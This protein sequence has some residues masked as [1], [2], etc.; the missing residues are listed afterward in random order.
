MNII[1]KVCLCIAVGAVLST[2]VSAQKNFTIAEATNGLSG[3]LAVQGLKQG[4]WRPGTN[5]LYYVEKKE[6]VEAWYSIDFPDEDRDELLTLAKLN[7]QLGTE[8]KSFPLMTWLDEDHVYIND[9]KK[10]HLG[11]VADDEVKDWKVW[12]TLPEKAQNITIDEKRNI[13]YTIDNNLYLNTP[14][15]K[16]LKV[17][18][19]SNKNIISGQAVHRNEFGIDRGIFLS[20]K[21]NYLA[22]YHMDQSMVNDYPIINWASD[23]ATVEN[24]KYP[25]AGGTSHQVLLKVYDPASGKTVT[26]KTGEGKD[27]YL[28]AVT[29]SPDEKHVYAGLL[30]REQNHLWLN[31]YDARTGAKLATLFEETSDKYV[32]PQHPLYFLPGSDNEFLWWSQKDGY[33]HLYLYNTNGE[34]LRQVTKG[35]WVVNEI[36]GFNRKNSEVLITGTKE[37][38]LGKN[39]YAANWK[40][41]ELRRLDKAEG[42]HTVSANTAGTYL[43]DVHTSDKVPRKYS[44]REVKG[45]YTKAL[46]VSEDPLKSYNRAEVRN[47]TLKA[48]DGT[49]LYGKLVLPPNFD[50]GKKY[51]TVVY[52]Y[53]GP[54]AQMIHNSYPASGNLWYEYMA[55]NGFIMFTIDGRGSSNRGLAF[56]QATFRKLGDVEMEDQLAGVTYLKSLPYVDAKRMGVHG[57]SYGGFM[58]TSLMLRHPGVFKAAVAGGPVMDWSMYEV[59]YTERY[60]DTPLENPE[61]YKNNNLYTKVKSLAGKLLLIHGASDDVVV[62][63]HSVKFLKACVDEN[64]QVDYFVYP[65]HPHNVRGKDRVHLMQKITDYFVEN[66]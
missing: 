24:I 18:D 15:G 62:W 7:K 63:Q 58:T 42:M 60:M 26:L 12:F 36:T 53:N 50:P 4:T 33:M 52:L 32:E 47:V 46:L 22:Y 20:P 34:Q 45:A 11:T 21:G 23:P 17:T 28:V 55:Q 31:K 38:P 40:N 54:H 13:A 30:N 27:H 43:Y 1:K 66:L 35:E 5:T 59:M 39:A 65:G 57:W 51:P 56:E 61:G 37:S 8:M 41:G 48:S 9:G 10:I 29:W 16:S 14:A 49:P 25:M 2:S 3:S 6:G 19:N 64:V 44:V